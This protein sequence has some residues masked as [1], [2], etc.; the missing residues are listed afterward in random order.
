[1]PRWNRKP[2]ASPT[3]EPPSAA[4]ERRYRTEP[5]APPQAF[6]AADQ[7]K[8]AGGIPAVHESARRHQHGL[9]LVSKA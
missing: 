4:A 5:R 9:G 1:M 6:R 7:I 3:N 8:L 2:T